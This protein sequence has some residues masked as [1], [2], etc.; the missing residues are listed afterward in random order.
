MDT[1]ELGSETQEGRVPE[2][3]RLGYRP[4]LDEI[5]GVAVAMVVVGHLWPQRWEFAGSVGVTIFFVLSG[6]LITRL[7]SEERERDGRVSLR[8]FY[9]RRA[10]RLLPALPFVLAVCAFVAAEHGTRV[11]RPLLASVFYVQNWNVALGD[12]DGPFVHLWSLAMEEQF[13]AIWPLV[14][15]A[16]SPAR[17][18]K[19]ALWSVPVL[20]VVR[21]FTIYGGWRQFGITGTEQFGNASGIMRVDALLAGCALA[22][23]TPPRLPRGWW[24]PCVAVMLYLCGDA[25]PFH[26]S[27][28]YTIITVV[29]CAWVCAAIQRT[30]CF[31]PLVWL[32][33]RSYGVYLWHV[34]VM[35]LTRNEPGPVIAWTLLAAAVSY[36]YVEAP[37]LTRSARAARRRASVPTVPSGSALSAAPA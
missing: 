12:M 24:V 26:Y 33:R 17:L 5:R 8:G 15:L 28:G 20:L 9:R 37:M 7:L 11:L 6:F 25:S 3:T 29:A 14:F 36:R 19:V 31:A 27:A 13:Y 34:P 35:W 23:V 16:V 21:V 30:R 32:G 22:F 18:H 1:A 4:A 2:G 10:F